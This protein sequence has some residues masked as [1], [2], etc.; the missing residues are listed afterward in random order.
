MMSPN[1][2]AV[3]GVSL[4]CPYSNPILG[5]VRLHSVNVDLIRD[6]GPVPLT[7][8]SLNPDPL[9][10]CT[11]HHSHPAPLAS[12]IPYTLQLAPPH[13]APNTLYPL[14]LTPYIPY[15]LHPSHPYLHPSYSTPYILHSL[16]PTSLIPCSLQP[17]PPHPTHP[18]SLT[19]Y[20]PCTY[21]NLHSAHTAPHILYPLH[22][23]L[24]YPAPL[25]TCIPHSLHPSHTASYTLYL[26]SSER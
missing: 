7:P 21:H 4:V 5:Y 6:S 8:C 15:N 14:H 16:Y 25:T 13:S 26:L 2:G 24:P 11:L 1:Q 10:S 17:A 18:I 9:I 22:P 20:T 23:A 3:M 19:T 12:S